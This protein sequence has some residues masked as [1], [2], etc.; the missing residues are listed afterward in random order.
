MDSTDTTASP[1]RYHHNSRVAFWHSNLGEV[2]ETGGL[3]RAV[4]RDEANVCDGEVLRS[5]NKPFLGEIVNPADNLFQTGQ[6]VRTDF[7]CRTH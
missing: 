1:S 3:Q 6:L 2:D 5:G 4:G 7:C